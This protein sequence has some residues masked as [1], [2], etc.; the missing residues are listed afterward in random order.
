MAVGFNPAKL[1][2]T[3]EFWQEF[4]SGSC[5]YYSVKWICTLQCTSSLFSGGSSLELKTVEKCAYGGL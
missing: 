1:K 3:E 4:V 2:G 5:W